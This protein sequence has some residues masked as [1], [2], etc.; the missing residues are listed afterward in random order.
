[1]INK[2]KVIL[3]IPFTF[4]L[5]L[6]ISCD[7]P[8]TNV[9]WNELFNSPSGKPVGLVYEDGVLWLT[10]WANSEGEAL[11]KLNANTGEVLQQFP[12]ISEHHEDLAYDGSNL[13]CCDWYTNELFV[14]D[15]DT[16]QVTTTYQ[17]VIDA[18]NPRLVGMAYENGYLWVGDTYYDEIYKLDI[19]TLEVESQF[20][21][22]AGQPEG[23]TYDGTYLYINDFI[24]NKMYK[25]D[26][27]GKLVETYEACY[28]RPEGL[29][30]DGTYI[31]SA[32]YHDDSEKIY[33][34]TIP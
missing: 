10:T 29:A 16:G 17:N 4:I 33:R 24:T 23:I 26:T 28:E 12:R 13:W 6:F 2:H 31:Y 25:Y 27:S 14:I 20:D 22:Y 11:W 5:A 7:E 1:M 19:S 8:A 32:S 30:N 18:E 9:N 21:F 3:L 15:P 34:T